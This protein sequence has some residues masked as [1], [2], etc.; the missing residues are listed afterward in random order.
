VPDFVSPIVS[1]GWVKMGRFLSTQDNRNNYSTLLKAVIA[2]DTSEF[3]QKGR[4]CP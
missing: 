3:L 1:P 4:F 2:G